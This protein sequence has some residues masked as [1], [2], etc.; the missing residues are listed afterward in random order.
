MCVVTFAGITVKVGHS[1]NFAFF[2]RASIV[3]FS[4]SQTDDLSSFTFDD[5]LH[6]FS[7][8]TG[9]GPARLGITVATI[10]GVCVLLCVCAWLSLVE[11]PRMVRQLE[12][13][14]ELRHGRGCDGSS[15]LEIG[16]N[17]SCEEGEDSQASDLLSV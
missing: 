15:M 17:R 10:L 5:L 13:E 11:G 9:H 14:D 1:H 6:R 3:N 12:L 8:I 7:E 4:F 16:T 2:L